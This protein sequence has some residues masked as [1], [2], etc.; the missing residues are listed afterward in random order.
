MK[1]KIVQHGSSSLT[2]TL[3][4]G[5]AKKY[6]L[7]KGDELEVIEEGSKLS[8]AT[9][10]EVDSLK[11]VIDP[12]KFGAFSKNNLAHVYMLGYDD[13]EIKFDDERT[14]NDIKSLIPDCI[15]L[16]II[17]QK[18]DKVFLKSMMKTHESE[19]E[20]SLRKSI[21]LTAEM[22][23][24][25]IQAIKNKEYQKLKEIRHLES[26]NNKFCMFCARI[27][28]KRGYKNAKRTNQMYEV[29]KHIERV[30]DE[31]KY[32]CD[33]LSDETIT[34]RK[35]V[36]DYLGQ[37]N[38]FHDNFYKIFYKF[39]PKLKE[40]LYIERKKLW[41]KGKEMIQKSKGK[42]SLLISNIINIINKT[43]DTANAYFALIL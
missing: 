11:K 13:I 4:F 29:V 14:L 28:N 30:A 9:Q 20:T 2:I 6:G 40:Q 26:I 7:N 31:Y 1:R 33:A 12:A 3:P 22:G 35:E 17:D 15:G 16:E 32:I 34:V 24:E 25:V 38:Q 5:W 21:Q 23:K 19:F 27:L 10:A 8:V 41:N 43:Y 18:S 37:A 36:I 42:E 39:D